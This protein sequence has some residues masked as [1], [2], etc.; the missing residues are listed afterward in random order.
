[1]VDG[2]V[3][4]FLRKAH[5]TSTWTTSDC[6]G[7]LILAAA[8]LLKGLPA[9]THWMKMHVLKSMGSKSQPNQRIVRSGKI[10]TAAGV[11]AGID[12]SLWLV[13]EIAGRERAEAIQW[14]MPSPLAIFSFSFG[15]GRE[16][17]IPAP[18]DNLGR[19]EDRSVTA[20]D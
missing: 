5:E 10:V 17:G 8:G 2:E 3:L 18:L 13:A 7:S 14:Y 12:L 4:D 20:F 16:L 15:L 1:M 11:S 19:K 9:T 6:T